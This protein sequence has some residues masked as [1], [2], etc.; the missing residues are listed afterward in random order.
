MPTKQILNLGRAGII[1]DIPSI[2]LPENAFTDGRNVRFNNESVE[3]IT[4]EAMYQVIGTPSTIEYGMHWRK[5]SIGYNIYFK[6]GK[7][8]DIT[9]A[10]DQ[11]NI[12]ALTKPVVKYFMV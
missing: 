7:I 2:L 4:G 10:S 6:D 5:P 8:K 3:T 9:D 11:L 1:K 12:Q